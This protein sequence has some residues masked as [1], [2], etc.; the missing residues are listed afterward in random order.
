MLIFRGLVIALCVV[1]SAAAAGDTLDNVEVA[2]KVPTAVTAGSGTLI[3]EVTTDEN[4]DG[5]KPANASAFELKGSANTYDLSA[6]K[7]TD[8]TVEKYD[9]DCTTNKVESVAYADS[10]DAGLIASLST[11]A[12]N[13]TLAFVAQSSTAEVLMKDACFKITIAKVKFGKD[14]CKKDGLTFTG[15]ETDTT[16]KLK[17]LTRNSAAITS[18]I[19]QDCAA[20]F[21]AATPAAFEENHACVCDNASTKAATNIF[22]TGTGATCN[23]TTGDN[24]AE[25]ATDVYECK[26]KAS[27][28]SSSSVV[29]MASIACFVIV[30]FRRFI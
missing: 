8:V 9:K 14:A 3:V 1:L 4:D 17:A 15:V 26:A 24:G 27:D 10:G 2:V 28:D 18:G 6:V 20:K 5:S 21:V 16:T 25:A 23:K 30:S 22:C 12:T 29:G 11:D 13:Q 19:C 7:S